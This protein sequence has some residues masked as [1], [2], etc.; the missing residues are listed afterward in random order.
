MINGYILH[1]Y[2]WHK[3]MMKQCS[4]GYCKLDLGC[5]KQCMGLWLVCQP[6]VHLK[7]VETFR[8]WCLLGGNQSIK[9]MSLKRICE[10]IT[11][12]S[13]FLISYLLAVHHEMSRVTLPRV[14]VMYCLRLLKP[15][16]KPNISFKNWFS[17]V[18]CHNSENLTC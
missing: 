13:L 17:R 14:M 4:N 9:V 12:L 2:I 6:V 3:V 18:F 1:D 10:F 8:N 11:I 15:W 16:S 7:A 5:G